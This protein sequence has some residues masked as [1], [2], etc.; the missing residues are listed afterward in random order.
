MVV[1]MELNRFIKPGTL[2]M[3]DEFYDREH[4]Y[5]ALMDYQK[6]SGKKVR[7]VA[8]LENFSKVCLEIL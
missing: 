4:E 6:I 1:L 3:F 5:K 2:L 7:G 8:H